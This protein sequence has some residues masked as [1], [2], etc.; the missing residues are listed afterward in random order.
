MTKY[1]S[2]HYGEVFWWAKRKP[3]G[4]QNSM[5]IC[6]NDP[7]LRSFM[8]VPAALLAGALA[9]GS[10][11]AAT[12]TPGAAPNA[13]AIEVSVLSADQVVEILDQ[14]SEGVPALET[15]QQNAAEPGRVLNLYG[16]RQKADKVVDLAVELARADAEL[17]S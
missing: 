7:M 3:G 9:Y 17:L 6:E 1:S 2:S 5:P 14:T 8:I 11:P 13:P 4:F 12:Q 16:K 10:D 15:Q